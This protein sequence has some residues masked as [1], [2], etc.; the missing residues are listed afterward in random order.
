MFNKN[1]KYTVTKYPKGN[2]QRYNSGNNVDTQML[3][4]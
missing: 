2:T 4:I 1:L 3:L